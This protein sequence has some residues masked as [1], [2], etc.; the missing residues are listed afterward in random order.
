MNTFVSISLFGYNY[1]DILC[2]ILIY[3]N[4]CLF[5]NQNEYVTRKFILLNEVLYPTFRYLL[6]IY[7]LSQH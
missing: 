1:R 3:F 7:F 6:M 5:F 2:F 4:W